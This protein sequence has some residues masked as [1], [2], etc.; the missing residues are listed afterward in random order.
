M[1][2]SKN[3]LEQECQELSVENER[4]INKLERLERIFQEQGLQATISQGPSIFT[5]GEKGT[6]PSGI[7]VH[8]GGQRMAEVAAVKPAQQSNIYDPGQKIVLKTNGNANGGG[9]KSR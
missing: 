8:R 5:T 7:P 9:S 2:Q 6:K 4:L 3:R 1:N